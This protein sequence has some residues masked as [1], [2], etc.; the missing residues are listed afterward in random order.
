M[1]ETVGQPCVKAGRVQLSKASKCH[2]FNSDIT[3]GLQSHS[4]D[5][6]ESARK[7]PFA[8]HQ[9]PAARQSLGE[10]SDESDADRQR[11]VVCVNVTANHV[12]SGTFVHLAVLSD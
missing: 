9:P 4:S 6:R 2:Y 11:V 10:V 5:L 7:H 3:A 12:E 1:P 8:R